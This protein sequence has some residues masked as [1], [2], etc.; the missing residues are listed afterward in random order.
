MNTMEE[1]R[2]EGLVR[3]GKRIGQNQKQKT[4]ILSLSFSSSPLEI[5][6]ESGKERVLISDV[7][8]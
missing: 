5:E 4:S 2:A 6:R 7:G 8:T 3:T 1:G